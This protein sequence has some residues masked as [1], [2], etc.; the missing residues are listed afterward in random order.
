MRLI[1]VFIFIHFFSI[2]GAQTSNTTCANM[3]Q[4]CL[5]NP[6][7]FI[8]ST[9]SV[10]PEQG[11][12]YGCLGFARNPSWFYF[13]IEQPGKHIFNIENTASEDIDFI[14]Y[15]PFN[16][17]IACDSLNDSSIVACSFSPDSLIIDSFT[18]HFSNEYYLILVTNYSNEPTNFS[19]AQIGGDGR[20]DCLFTP[21]CGFQN[22]VSQVSSCDTNAYTFTFTGS[23][24]LASPPENGTITLAAGPSQHIYYAPFDS[25]LQFAFSD[26]NPDSLVFTFSASYSSDSECVMAIHFESP[27]PC[28]PCRQRFVSNSPLCKGK[29][30]YIRTQQN[31]Q[32]NANYQWNGPLNFTSYQNQLLIPNMS[33]ENAGT[34]KLTIT[35]S[36]CITELLFPVTVKET[37][38]AHIS[39]TKTTY[40]EYETLL[41][42]AQTYDSVSYNWDGPSSLVKLGNTAYRNSINPFDSGKYDL[43]HYKNGCSGLHD[44]IDITVLP[45]PH[46]QIEGKTSVNPNFPTWYSITGNGNNY[47]WEFSNQTLLIDSITNSTLGDSLVIFWT[48]KEGVTLIKATGENENG[49]K[50]S[51]EMVVK[52]TRYDDFDWSKQL[53][54]FAVFPNPASDLIVILNHQTSPLE[55][56]LVDLTGRL[57]LSGVAKPTSSETIDLSIVQTGLYLLI[58]E[59]GQNRYVEKILIQH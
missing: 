38:D 5:D 19:I 30:L 58:L 31:P 37:P 59:N 24:D 7:N 27:P 4:I 28:N 52:V 33:P 34:Y 26:L 43:Y 32:S 23:I 18:S 9:N 14:L 1:A 12:D 55:Y 20:T 47:T 40:C 53:K 8:A 16:S 39:S 46:F 22:L 56:K 11:P 57:L 51:K 35:G 15:G 45:G 50:S 29:T 17:I 42:E 21:K 2:I 44:S 3:F 13:T 25:T 54:N 36:N 6:I 10:N 48:D 49:C 41:L